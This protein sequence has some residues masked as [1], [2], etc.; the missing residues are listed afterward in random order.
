MSTEDTANEEESAASEPVIDLPAQCDLN[1]TE[2]IIDRMVEAAD[3]DNIVIDASAVTEMSSA[4]ALAV[5]AFVKHRADRSP[6]AAIQEP[7]SQFID[8]F[9]ELGLFEDLMKMEFRT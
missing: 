1:E 3:A 7:T 5:V 9:S 8:A 6:P 4:C 2:A